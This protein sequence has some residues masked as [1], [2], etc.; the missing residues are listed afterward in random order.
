L[1]SDLA[2]AHAMILAERAARLDAE[3]AV[4]Q[5]R[6]DRIVLDLEL[7]HLRFQLAK[8]WCAM[9]GQSSEHESKIG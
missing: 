2:S 4:A 7:E 6:K 9:F 1:P 3:A 8:A 5:A